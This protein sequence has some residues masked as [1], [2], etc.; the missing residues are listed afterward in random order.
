M[1]THAE[2]YL[3]RPGEHLVLEGY[4]YWS[5]GVITGDYSHWQKAQLLYS[6]K[7]GHTEGKLLLMALSDFTRAL[8]L[9]A[10][11]P[12]KTSPIGCQSLCRDE[13]LI[14]GLL[15]G[16]QHDEQTTIILCLDGL[17]CGKKSEEVLYVAEILA[18]TLKSLDKILLPV[19]CK[20]IKSILY[21]NSVAKSL[22]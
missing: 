19:P 3:Y 18:S 11:C 2:E 9:C 12:L 22:H 6:E 7:L 16:L 13:V 14:L 5:S 10:T 20:V 1:S 15:S 17:V 4:R 8:G 21:G